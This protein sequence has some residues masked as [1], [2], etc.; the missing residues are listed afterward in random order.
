MPLTDQLYLISKMLH[1]SEHQRQTIPLYASGNAQFLA[2]QSLTAAVHQTFEGVQTL[3]E[4]GE[5][6]VVADHTEGGQSTVAG[7]ASRLGPAFSARRLVHI[8][9][10][11]GTGRL[12]GRA[13]LR[14]LNANLFGGA[15]GPGSFLPTGPCPSLPLFLRHSLLEGAVEVNTDA[16]TRDSGVLVGEGED[17]RDIIPQAHAPLPHTQTALW[18]AEEHDIWGQGKLRVIL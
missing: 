2:Q 16:I 4:G 12:Q 10:G 3:S 13:T 18:L 7:P 9:G 6:G 8:G 15:G 11:V 17:K 5:E 1:L 14:T